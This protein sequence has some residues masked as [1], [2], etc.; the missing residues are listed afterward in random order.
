MM[1]SYVIAV[2]SRLKP[3]RKIDCLPNRL[4]ESKTRCCVKSASQAGIQFYDCQ[5]PI[6]SG[7][8]PARE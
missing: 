3:G 7:F 2:G 1:Q 8:P 4:N 5:C 6:T